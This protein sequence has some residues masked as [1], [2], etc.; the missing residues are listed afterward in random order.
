MSFLNVV[1]SGSLEMEEDRN[2]PFALLLGG[3]PDLAR[4]RAKENEFVAIEKKENSFDSHLKKDELKPTQPKKEGLQNE[5]SPSFMDS[6]LVEM[7]HNIKNALASVYHAT[8]L[9]M[10]KYDDMEI[11]KHSRTRVKEEIKKID[12][13]L[14][15]LLNFINVNTPISKASA[16]YVILEEILEASDK[17]LRQKDIKI[18]KKYEND[19]PDTFIHPEQ[20]RFI[21]H[22][23]LQYAILSTPSDQVIGFLMKSSD[24]NNG[25]G[26]ENPSP[27]NNRRYVEVMIGFDADGEPGNK[28]GNLSETK[29]DQNGMADLILRLAKDILERNHGTMI[30]TRKRSETVLTL[31]FPIERRKVVYYEPITL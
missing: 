4:F 28:S 5:H 27:E 23:A 30:E 13:V 24:P 2:S 21:L 26:A 1:N 16:L 29:E 31:R 25:T 14:N 17:Q 19:L 20:V 9:T 7:V 12:S 6:F 11:R 8:V 3:Q 15:T 22:S 18:Y 10:D